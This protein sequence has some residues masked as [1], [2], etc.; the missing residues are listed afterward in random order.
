[1]LSRKI[2]YLVPCMFALTSGVGIY[3]VLF[4]MKSK[5]GSNGTTNGS[6]KKGSSINARVLVGI[7]GSSKGGGQLSPSM[8][9][10]PSFK[11]VPVATK[12]EIQ[13]NV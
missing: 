2:S 3:L 12:F 10:S 1:M 13:Q 4:T 5:S 6:S 11:I 8:I 7:S 9:R